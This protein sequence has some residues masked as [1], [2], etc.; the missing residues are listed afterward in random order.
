MP[1]TIKP[2]DSAPHYASAQTLIDKAWAIA[3][4]NHPAVAETL[5]RRKALSYMRIAL[6]VLEDSCTYPGRTPK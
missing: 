5:I 1:Y 2:D 3:R 4:E 6:E